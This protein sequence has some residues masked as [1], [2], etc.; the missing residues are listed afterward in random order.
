MRRGKILALDYGSK[1]VGLAC[2]DELAIA[3]TPLPSIPNKSRKSL[4]ER[5]ARLAA[6]QEATKVVVGIPLHMDGR[7]GPEADRVQNFIDQLRSSLEL[8]VHGIDER[9]STVEAEEIWKEMT[10]RQRTKY[11]S[12]DSLAA[13]RILQRYLEES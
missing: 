6:E 3:V 12:I 2:C 4:L 10:E 9:L 7:A 8:P 5:V 13:A 1:N 11:R